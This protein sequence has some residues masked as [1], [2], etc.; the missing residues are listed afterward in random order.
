MCCFSLRELQQKNVALFL[1]IV[2]EEINK[3]HKRSIN[4]GPKK[5]KA[6]G[7]FENFHAVLKGISELSKFFA[8]GKETDQKSFRVVSKSPENSRDTDLDVYYTDVYGENDDDY[9]DY[10]D[11]LPEEAVSNVREAVKELI[12]NNQHYTEKV[13]ENLLNN[14]EK[15]TRKNCILAKLLFPQLRLQELV[16]LHKD[17]GRGLEKVQVSYIEIG[18]VFARLQER[19]LVYCLV[20]SRMTHMKQFLADQRW[21]DEN[22]QQLVETLQCKAARAELTDEE[23]KRKLESKEFVPQ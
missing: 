21:S 14:Y 12:S 3:K 13:L 1:Q 17:L 18:S 19:F 5:E 23:F 10:I 9:N 8:Q 20:V 22:I 2:D 11:F 15:K 6:L 16:D 4:F 7:T